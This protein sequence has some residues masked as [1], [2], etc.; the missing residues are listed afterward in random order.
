MAKL[1]ASAAILLVKDVVHSANWY[2]DKL[3]F[4]IAGLYH[5]PPGFGIIERDG[6]YIMLQKTNPALIKPNW[7]IVDKTNNIYFWVEDVDTLYKQ[8]IEAGATIDYTLYET[9]WGTK[10]FGINDPDEYDVTFGEILN[11]GAKSKDQ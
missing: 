8:F 4:S 3:G 10:E 2:R 7:K 1:L 11:K 5:D 6:Q 9:P